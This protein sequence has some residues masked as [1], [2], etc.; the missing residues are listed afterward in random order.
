MSNH[1]DGATVPSGPAPGAALQPAVPGSVSVIYGERRTRVVLSGEIDA[2]LAP[3]LRQAAAD[4]EAA[5]S[6]V[7]VDVR[8]VTFMDSAG[9]AFL[10]RTAARCPGRPVLVQPPDAVRFL[11]DVTAMRPLVDVVDEPL[12]Q[13]WN[14]GPGGEG[15]DLVA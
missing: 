9:V 7:E 14:P 8:H 6:P 2:A 11:L 1:S 15:P 13:P 4:A 12:T 5:G 3:D 10:A